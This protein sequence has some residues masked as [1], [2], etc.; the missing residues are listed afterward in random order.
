MLHGQVEHD[1]WFAAPPL[2]RQHAREDLIEQNNFRER[3]VVLIQAFS[4]RRA[5]RLILRDLQNVS[6]MNFALSRIVRIQSHVR[7]Q[8]VRSQLKYA[9]ILAEIRRKSNLTTPNLL[10]WTMN[11][12]GLGGDQESSI[13]SEDSVEAALSDALTCEA[14][15]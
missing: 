5:A 1:P 9:L 7:G 2:V 13:G 14:G 8:Q 6:G 15:E 11:F 3:Q 12:P 4:R 10:H